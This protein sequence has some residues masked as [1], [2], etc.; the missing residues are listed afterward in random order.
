MLRTI[1]GLT[2]IELVLA[3]TL[4]LV[5][6]MVVAVSYSVGVRSFTSEM[7]RS[8]IFHDGQRALD[9][10]TEELRESLGVTV[11]GSDNI[12]FWWKD[13]NENTT[14]EADEV[15]EYSLSGQTLIRT[16]GSTPEPVARNVAAF[17]LDYD[18][19][20]APTLVTVVLT[21]QDSET[22]VSLEGKAGLRNR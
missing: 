20:A 12:R 3:I 1:K 8:D 19:P 6:L 2:L 14:L 18:V 4:S 15:V 13:L 7:S 16:L 9:N 10:I 17:S 22:T 5:A 11:A 21:M